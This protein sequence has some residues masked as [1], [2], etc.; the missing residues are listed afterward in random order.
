MLPLVGYRVPV[1]I[2]MV[3]DLPAPLGPS[4][5]MISSSF[6]LKDTSLTAITGT[7]F[8]KN[9]AFRLSLNPLPR[10]YVVYLFVRLF[11]VIIF[12]I[13]SPNLRHLDKVVSY[14]CISKY[15]I[16]ETENTVV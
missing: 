7:F 15:Q 3:V 13:I 14:I 12:S 16:K 5:P 11:T 8:L 2:F 1:S 4:I 6:T 9:K 10:L